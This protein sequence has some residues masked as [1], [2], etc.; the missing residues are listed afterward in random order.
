MEMLKSGKACCIPFAE[1]FVDSALEFSDILHPIS[2]ILPIHF[3][4]HADLYTLPEECSPFRFTDLQACLSEVLS[5]FPHL[6]RFQFLVDIDVDTEDHSWSSCVH[7]C[8]ALAVDKNRSG[9]VSL[10]EVS[11]YVKAGRDLSGV[12]DHAHTPAQMQYVQSLRAAWE[13]ADA[14]LV[15]KVRE[16]RLIVGA[17]N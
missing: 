6:S 9:D 3:L 2:L 14:L 11:V 7:F 10:I 1:H 4:L 5:G 15:G 13:E 17:F 16:M 12:G 8:A